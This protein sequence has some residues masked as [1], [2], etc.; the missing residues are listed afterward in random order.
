[1][2]I[3]VQYG[4]VTDMATLGQLAGEAQSRQAQRAFDVQQN[5]QERNLEAQQQ[6]QRLDIDSR[7]AGQVRD[8]AFTREMAQFDR[9]AQLE[10]FKRQRAL[11]IEKLETQ[12]RHDLLMTERAREIEFEQQLMQMQRREAEKNAKLKGAELAR[13]K[14]LLGPAE[15]QRA[16]TGI[17]TGMDPDDIFGEVK[18]PALSQMER[19]FT[20]YQEV[21]QGYQ[22]GKLDEG[23]FSDSLDLMDPGTKGGKWYVPLKEGGFEPVNAVEQTNIDNAMAGIAQIGPTL[24]AARN[25]WLNPATKAGMVNIATGARDADAAL[26]GAPPTG[27]PNR[28]LPNIK[29]ELELASMSLSP[30]ERSVIMDILS[31]GTPE[32]IADAYATMQTLTGVPGTPAPEPIQRTMGSNPTGAFKL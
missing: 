20:G 12:Q 6:A 24:A 30:Q 27:L 18:A 13:Q 21:L 10:T 3:R 22:Y 31:L 28:P 11:Q 5:M 32:A 7:I 26:Q 16:V 29:A 17:V 19:L 1:M 8:Q 15:Y 14:G 25:E 23:I 4:S 9:W 2:A